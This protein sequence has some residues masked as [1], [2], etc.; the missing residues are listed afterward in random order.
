MYYYIQMGK[1]K[2]HDNGNHFPRTVLN[3]MNSVEAKNRKKM[4]LNDKKWV[5]KS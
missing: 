1:K 2:S 5:Y 4:E 3:N